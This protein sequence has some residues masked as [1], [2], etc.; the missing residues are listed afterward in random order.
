M[1]TDLDDRAVELLLRVAVKVTDCL[2]VGAVVLAERESPEDAVTVSGV[3][4]ALTVATP[5]NSTVMRR[6]A[7]EIGTI[8]Y[9]R[10]GC[11]GKTFLYIRRVGRA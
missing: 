3:E 4:A 9:A 8:L 11:L 10:M 2:T 6:T 5:A 1:V 7:T